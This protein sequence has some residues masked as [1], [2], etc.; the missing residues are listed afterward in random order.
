ML[1]LSRKAMNRKTAATALLMIMIVGM[2]CSVFNVTLNVAKA[3]DQSS[4]SNGNPNLWPMFRGDLGHS[5]YSTSFGPLTNKTLWWN[6]ISNPWP[7]SIDYDPIVSQGIV[8]VISMGSY[9]CALNATTGNQMWAFQTGG[10]IYS[11]PAIADNILYVVSENNLLAL[12]RTSGAELWNNTLFVVTPLNGNTDY[13]SPAIDNGLVYVG[14]TNRLYAIN[15]STG[16]TV[17]TYSD[18]LAVVSSPAIAN[19]IVYV[20]AYDAVVALNATDGSQ[21]WSYQSNSYF[22]PSSLSVDNDAVYTSTYTLAGENDF[23]L[24]GVSTIYAAYEAAAL[25]G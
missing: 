18:T 3:D 13:S 8:F 10:D 2:F 11:T 17:W 25:P 1:K 22:M 16:A 9:I 14:S 20:A 4:D 6:T 19:G 21:L 5:G 12:I 23:G 15:A 7:Y 24:W